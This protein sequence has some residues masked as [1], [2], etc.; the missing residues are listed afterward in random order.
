[1]IQQ[2]L[3]VLLIR[4]GCFQKRQED[5]KS[6]RRLQK[7]DKECAG[8]WQ[9]GAKWQMWRR[10]MNQ[11]CLRRCFHRSDCVSTAALKQKP[12]SSTLSCRN[13]WQIDHDTEIYGA[14]PTCFTHLGGR[15]KLS[16]HQKHNKKTSSVSIIGERRMDGLGETSRKSF[17]TGKRVPTVGI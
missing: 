14:P 5:A 7:S 8:F 10:E 6:E 4:Q 1:M 17:I 16:L 12:G 3:G 2:F 9:T 13:R 15:L 11:N